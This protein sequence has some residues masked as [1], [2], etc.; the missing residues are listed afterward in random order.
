MRRGG[1]IKQKLRG[2]ERGGEGRGKREG[3]GTIEE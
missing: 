2:R 1:E 3:Y